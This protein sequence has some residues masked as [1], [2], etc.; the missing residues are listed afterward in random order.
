[1]E[2]ETEDQLSKRGRESRSEM[3]ENPPRTCSKH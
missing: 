3:E 2:T 1:M